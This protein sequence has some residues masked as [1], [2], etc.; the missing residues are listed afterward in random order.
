MTSVIPH[1]DPARTG[2]LNWRRIEFAVLFVALPLFAYWQG[3]MMR[4]WV[5]PQIWLLAA[6]ASVVL[7]RDRGF[8]RRILTWPGPGGNGEL[9]R[10]AA[11]F[12]AGGCG[13]LA[14]VA[15]FL[16]ERLFWMPAERPTLWLLVLVLYP[17]LSALPQELFFRVFFFHRYA[18]IFPGMRAMIA[19]SSASFALA[20]L[21][22]GNPVA[23]VLSLVG[24]TL[25]SISYLRS[26]GLLQPALEH[27]L[28]GD[29]IFTVGLGSY[30]YG[31]RF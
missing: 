27:A 4:R 10:I 17:V 1:D 28:W 21:Q 30:F 19:A 12:A 16:P 18:G 6:A 25:F 23:P 29:W 26:R 7:L 15:G 5:L 22:L 8:D 14:L 3:S 20:H 13:L 11:L 9:K 24:G 31:G 2:R